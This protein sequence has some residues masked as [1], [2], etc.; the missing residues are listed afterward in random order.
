VLITAA[1]LAALAWAA[2]ATCRE[3]SGTTP[4]RGVRIGALQG[5][6]IGLLVLVVSVVSSYSL[7]GL[8]PEAKGLY[9]PDLWGTPT[10]AM[11]YTIAVV[12]VV[13]AVSGAVY[14]AV[15]KRRAKPVGPHLEPT[16]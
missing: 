4:G 6:S 10:L 16:S 8:P 12:A 11:L 9:G 14:G 1:V 2:I 5:L 7:R 3:A 15:E 13:C